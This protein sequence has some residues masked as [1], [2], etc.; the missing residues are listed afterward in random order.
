MTQT[1]PIDLGPA[2]DL[3][4]RVLQRDKRKFAIK[5]EEIYWSQ[6]EDFAREDKTTVSKLIASTTQDTRDGVNRTSLL[7]C[8]VLDR[9]R[10]RPQRNHFEGQSFDL[11]SLIA[12]CPLPVAVITAER[13]LTAFNPAFSEL[14]Q[15]MRSDSTGSDRAIQL[16]F[17]EPLPKI[18]GQLVERPNEIRTYQV[19]VQLGEGQPRLFRARFAIA[20]RSR[21]QDPL[22]VIYLQARGQP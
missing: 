5:L 1:R 11:L 16:S 15:A 9:L 13:K 8:Y 18:I 17:S 19:G 12:T 6:L 21:I 2:M 3:R 14:I 10:R 7:R 4:L 22:V 20:D